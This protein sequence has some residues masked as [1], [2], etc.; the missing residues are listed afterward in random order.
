M[1]MEV[2]IG[3]MHPRAR[4]ARGSENGGG[5]KPFSRALGEKMAMS[6]P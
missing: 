2:K 3:G 5:K 6:T 4:N 1:K